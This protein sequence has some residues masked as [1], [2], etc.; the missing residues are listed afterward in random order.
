MVRRRSENAAKREA[1]IQEA[2]TGLTDGVY[3]SAYQA[4]KALGLNPK[5]LRNRVAGGRSVQE[6]KETCQL[7]SEGEEKALARW[8]TR[9]TAT[10]YPPR[11]DL[12]REMAEEI[13]KQRLAKINDS[14]IENV[15]YPPLGKEWVQRFLQRHPRLQTV[16]GITIEAARI[17]S[18]S[19]EALDHWFSEFFRVIQ[20]KNIRLED[21]Y[22]MDETGF[23]IGELAKSHVIIDK[24]LRT[25]L[26]AK[27]GRQEWVSI[28]E[29]I[30]ANGT[31]IPPFTIFKGEKPLKEWIPSETDGSWKFSANSKG[32]TSNVHGVEWLRRVFEPATRDKADGRY[33]IL[34]CDGHD[35][36]IT[37]EFVAHCYN[38]KIELL[39][40]PPHTS[41]L[42]QP[43]DVGLFSPLKTAM[44][45][46]IY[47][48]VSTGVHRIQKVE[49]FR[50]YIKAREIAF[51]PLNIQSGWRGAGLFPKDPQ[52]VFRHLPP[53][54]PA[55]SQYSVLPT[56]PT[57]LFTNLPITDS[58]MGADVLRLTNSALNQY[59]AM[60]KPVPSPVRRFIKSLTRTSEVLAAEVTLITQ[61]CEEVKR[62]LHARKQRQASKRLVVEGEIHITRP[63]IIEGIVDAEKNTREKQAK[64][65]NNS[66]RKTPIVIS[67]TPEDRND[68]IVFDAI[69]VLARP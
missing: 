45:G 61:E 4:A 26:Q 57:K 59:L 58:P 6:A 15:Y 11:H 34:I 35:S 29:C 62:V 9:L 37:G 66:E 17:K 39:L 19:R 18:A 44:S 3:T 8:I 53:S 36:H 21:I 63:E 38:N 32:W 51:T 67:N 41:H 42:L 49:W 47:Q 65:G 68:A 31:I 69:Q 33:R 48:F 56:S 52:K 54:P 16:F 30:C 50:H 7:L 12:L 23:G 55:I 28:I 20:E 24:T 14:S 60:E 43:L 13:R 1:L 5:T 46:E 64:K 25:R 22:N 10:G 27:P 2:L 40:L